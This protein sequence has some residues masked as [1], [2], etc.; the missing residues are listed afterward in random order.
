[1]VRV[2]NNLTVKYTIPHWDKISDAWG[3]LARKDQNTILRKAT[4]PALTPVI[5][6][7]RG[8]LRSKVEK[9]ET[10]YGVTRRSLMKQTKTGKKGSKKG[11][12]FGMV[13]ARRGYT[14]F[15]KAK[16]FIR[17]RN[18]GKK[19]A[20]SPEVVRGKGNKVLVRKSKHRRG[21]VK[22]TPTNYFYF[23]DKGNRNTRGHGVLPSAVSR[24]KNRSL[25]I[26]AKG[27]G[28]HYIRQVNRIVGSVKGTKTL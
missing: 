15:H 20:R 4:S 8:E 16:S 25:L 1:M 9:S 26:F 23:M 5:A 24:S 19:G 7:L 21:M 22:R 10:S 6:A 2:S 13:G 18:K 27:F 3:K 11:I 17:F 28:K 12:V 14:E